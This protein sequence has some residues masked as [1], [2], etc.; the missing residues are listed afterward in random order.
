MGLD[1]E[2]L[3]KLPQRDQYIFTY[4]SRRSG[5]S[6][7]IYYSDPKLDKWKKKDGWWPMLE[8]N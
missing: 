8:A 5:S 3:L 6:M 1:D 7:Y 2:K 4:Y